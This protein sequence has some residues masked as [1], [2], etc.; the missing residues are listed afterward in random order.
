MIECMFGLLQCHANK[1]FVPISPTQKRPH[2]P[3]RLTTVPSGRLDYNFMCA[4]LQFTSSLL[5]NAAIHPGLATLVCNLVSSHGTEKVPSLEPWAVEYNSGAS[6][7]VG[8]H[9]MYATLCLPKALI[10]T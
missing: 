8:A 9:A 7:E 10:I 4:C 6:C 3:A 5:S 2:P 1:S